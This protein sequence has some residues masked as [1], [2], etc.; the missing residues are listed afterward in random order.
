MANPVG[1]AEGCDLL[2]FILG[3]HETTENQDQKI[4]AFGSSY[5]RRPEIKWCQEYPWPT[6]Y[7]T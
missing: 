7:P 6:L 4:A 2:I 5:R 3:D 1:A